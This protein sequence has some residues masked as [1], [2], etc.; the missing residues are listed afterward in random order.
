MNTLH[1]PVLPN[2]RRLARPGS[3]LS[4]QPLL[5]IM[6]RNDGVYLYYNL[7]GVRLED[8]EL[9]LDGG[10]LSLQATARLA[11]LG[12]KVHALEFSDIM[13]ES[14]LRVPAMVDVKRIEA[15]F[16][17]GSLRVFLPSPG[18]SAPVRIPVIQG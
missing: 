3:V 12:G 1:C 4:A 15:S 16:V 6:E 10:V 8:I 7:P 14:T 13:Y 5:D 18:K 9:E 11:P 17:N 2:R